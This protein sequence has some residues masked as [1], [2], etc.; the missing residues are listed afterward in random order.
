MI[1]AVILS[2]NNA[3]TIQRTLVSVAWCDEIICIDDFSSDRTAGIVRKNKADVLQR[4][5][6]D[7]FAAQRNFGLENARGEWILFVDSDEVVSRELKEEILEKITNHN[8]QITKKSQI[9]NT[10]TTSG[11]YIKRKDFFLGR[12]LRHGE[13]AH[14]TL[15]RLAKR[16]AGIWKRPVHEDW[17]INGTTDTLENPLLH[18]P[19]TD[20]AQFITEINRYT[21]INAH[22]LN[23]N[24]VRS[25]LFAIV[26][27]PAGKFFQNYFLRLGFLDN[28]PGCIMAILMSFH[29]FLTRAKLFILNRML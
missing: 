22:Y 29:S 12:E 20:V 17:D 21:T 10:N 19:H 18:Y 16:G 3:S 24:G 23:K 4:H 8:F 13:T 2:K 6:N 11:F 7:D 25:N 26:A 1:S 14:V 9:S 15:L 28:T 5:L 27:Y